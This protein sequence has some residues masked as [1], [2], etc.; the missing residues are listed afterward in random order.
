LSYINREHVS[1]ALRNM[2]QFHTDLQKLHRGYGLCMLDNTGRRNILM[3]AAQEEFF[4]QALSKSYTDV[5]NSGKTGEPD[6]LIGQ[7]QKELECK[8]TSPTPTGGV[9]LQT[10]FATLTKK[11]HLDY[12]YVIADRDFEKFVVLHYTDLTSQEFANPSQS[13]RGK[14][15]LVKHLAE[16]KCQVLW[17][18]VRNKNEEELQK[19]NEK[20]QVCSPRAVKQREKLLSSIEYWKTQP[21]NYSYDYEGV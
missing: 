14:A 11:G 17:G 7:L 8:I 18:N 1:Q 2:Q 9:N 13:S 10:D 20:L 6:I 15:K 21:T 5:T 3:S 16:H 19:L 12:L 4:S